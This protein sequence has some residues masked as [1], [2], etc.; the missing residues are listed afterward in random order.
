[1]R[2]RFYVPSSVQD[3]PSSVTRCSPLSLN[4]AH[5]L[6]ARGLFSRPSFPFFSSF[7]LFLFPF[8]L[9]MVPRETMVSSRRER[10]RRLALA[11]ARVTIR[12]PRPLS[13][14]SFS[15]IP[16][17]GIGRDRAPAGPSALDC[18]RALIRPLVKDT[19]RNRARD[20]RRITLVCGEIERP[21]SYPLCAP[22]LRI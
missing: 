17:P 6:Y 2:V 7:L 22:F 1:V 9:F 18:E 3:R 16:E 19:S 4:T 13:K 10:H 20:K 21:V 12:N 5:V 8:F 15:R 11:S 14:S